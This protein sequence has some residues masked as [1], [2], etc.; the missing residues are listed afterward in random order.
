MA[1]EL[2]THDAWTGDELERVDQYAVEAGTDWS[3]NIGGTGES[4]WPMH[5][6]YGAEAL[7]GQRLDEMFKGGARLL[8]LRWGSTVLGAWKTESWD[9][10]D[11][12]GVAVVKAVELRSEWK[13]RKTYGVDAYEA[14]TLTVTN[15]SHAGA[16]RAVL[17]RWMQY[18]NPDWRYPVDLPADEGGGFSQTWEFWKKLT[19]EDLIS[20]IEAEGYE[21][22]LRP[23]LTAGRQLRFQTL[24]APRVRVALSSFNL[25]DADSPLG[26]VR[27]MKTSAEQI[28]GGQGVGEGTGQDQPVR[29][30]GAG[31]YDTPIRDAGRKFP[32]LDGDRLQAA[33]NAWYAQARNPAA[34]WTVGSFTL[35]D[36][37]PAEDVA[38]AR[39]WELE[40]VRHPVFPLGIHPLRLVAVSGSWST[41]VKTE[42]QG[43]V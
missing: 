21:V 31:P 38:L 42:V 7:S 13:W 5:A 9:Y 39:G 14:G 37:H 34:Q 32:D 2:W 6:G 10:G 27:Y 4:T 8:S 35:S 18:G 17:E 43:V 1:L 26:G 22:V 11:T 33:T 24:V 12:E 16:V 28:T 29:W 20:Q 36:D 30:A 41:Q 25:H 40:V 15:R 19:I 23:Y 3:T